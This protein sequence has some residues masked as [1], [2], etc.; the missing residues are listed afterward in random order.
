MTATVN[1]LNSLDELLEDEPA[2]VL[3][4]VQLELQCHGRKG[5]VGVVQLRV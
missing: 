5:G 3:P 1:Q 2:E 4:G